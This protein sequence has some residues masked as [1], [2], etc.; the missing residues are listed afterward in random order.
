MYQQAAALQINSMIFGLVSNHIKQ[1]I[2]LDCLRLSTIKAV[3]ILRSDTDCITMLSRDDQKID[4]KVS[5]ILNENEILTYKCVASN[6][7]KIVNYSPR[8]YA[9][10]Y[11]TG[12][13]TLLTCGLRLPYQIRQSLT[14]DKLPKMIT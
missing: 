7:K 11:Q 9:I 2:V 6:I 5:S 3:T 12:E 1:K 13:V 8:S 10:I 4:A 14:E